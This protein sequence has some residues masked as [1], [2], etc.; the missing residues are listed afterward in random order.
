[1]KLHD[2][3]LMSIDTSPNKQKT[4]DALKFCQNLIQFDDVLFI[5]N[6]EFHDDNFNANVKLTDKIKNVSDYSR[7][8][9]SNLNDYISTPYV[10]IVQ[11]DGFILNPRNWLDD[12]LN[13]DYIGA[14]WPY[15]QPPHYHPLYP[16]RV[17]NGGFSLR[18]KKLLTILS[19]I[20]VLPSGMWPEDAI[21]C[22]T[23][24]DSKPYPDGRYLTEILREEKQV[25]F[26]PFELA[27][28]FSVENGTWDGQ[29]GFHGKDTDISKTHKIFSKF[30]YKR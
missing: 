19:D 28:E 26:A 2:I 27:S 8:M 24:K 3:T 25:K 15:R 11:H 20:K 14:P 9:I 5:T 22:N 7:F 18:S 12:Y 10:L 23:S 4:I 1:M 16:Y 21:I 29:F 30:P 13:Y 17:G 6:E